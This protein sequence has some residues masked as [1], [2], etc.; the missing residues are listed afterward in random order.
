VFEVERGALDL[1]VADVL[2]RRIVGP[3][4]SNYRARTSSPRLE[5][6]SAHCYGS[7]SACCYQ[8]RDVV[9][10]IGSPVSSSDQAER[11]Q[12]EGRAALG[13]VADEPRYL[14]PV[15]FATRAYEPS[16]QREVIYH[17]P[18]HA[19]ALARYVASASTAA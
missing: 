11:R 5:Y 8:F 19:A 6:W 4:G 1:R 16:D 10:D 7:T 14:S 3:R 9:R 15:M 18:S 12:V 17:I 13:G 2:R